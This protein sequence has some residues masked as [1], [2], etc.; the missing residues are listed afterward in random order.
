MFVMLQSCVN[1]HVHYIIYVR[2]CVQM[3]SKGIKVT[4]VCPSS[5]KTEMCEKSFVGTTT[6]ED[7]RDVTNL[8]SLSRIGAQSAERYYR[9]G[10]LLVYRLSIGQLYIL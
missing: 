4:T 9:T 10:V 7:N 3:H 1:M 2:I 5:V 8:V 6:Q